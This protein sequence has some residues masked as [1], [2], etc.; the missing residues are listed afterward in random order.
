MTTAD[1]IRNAEEKVEKAQSAL[2]KTQSGLSAAED[3][4][5]TADEASRHPVLITL[6]VLLLVGVV[7][8]L[9]QMSKSEDQV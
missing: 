7:W 5:V 9:I 8:M 1:K 4:A 3:V 2:D 6:G